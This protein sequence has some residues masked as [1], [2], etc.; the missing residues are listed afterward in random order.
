VERAATDISRLLEQVLSILHREF[1]NPRESRP[2]NMQIQGNIGTPMVD[3]KL[4]A[5]ALLELLRN[6]MQAQP[7]TGIHVA[8]RWEGESRRLVIEVHDDGLGMDAYALEH[9]MDPFFSAKPA[10]RRLGLGLA[11][12]RQNALAQGGDIEL[13]STPDQGTTAVLTLAVP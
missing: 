2:V 5:Q 1:T 8:V 13:R 6:A 12:A 9:A 7:K 11:R 4:V 10:G 3:P